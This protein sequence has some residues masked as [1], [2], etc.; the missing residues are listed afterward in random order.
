MPSLPY[1]FIIAKSAA[2]SRRFC[3]F[4]FRHSAMLSGCVNKVL[5]RLG[6]I[7]ITAN[8]GICKIT[9]NNYIVFDL[10]HGIG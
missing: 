2:F 3:P 8:D 5:K 4:Q 9:P 7:G 10:L 6:N 1:I